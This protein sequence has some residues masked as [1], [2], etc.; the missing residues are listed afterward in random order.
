M[1]AANPR[2]S[3][4]LATSCVVCAAVGCTLFTDILNTG[5]ATEFGLDPATVFPSQGTVMVAFRNSTSFPAT[6]AAFKA[7]DAGDYSR[8]GRNFS[9]P[10]AAND[11]GN[12]V[13]ECPVEV[14]AP[15]ALGL[16]F[17]YDAS[18]A[19]T[20]ETDSGPQTIAYAGEPL[21]AGQTFTC[22]YVIE[23]RLSLST[24]Q[25]QTQ[26][27]TET[28][29]EQTTDPLAGGQTTQGDQ[30]AAQTTGQQQANTQYALSVRVIPGR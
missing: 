29:G 9:V 27:E 12:E 21:I 8:G 2:V 18:A 28:T 25:T 17:V 13:L 1:K 7:N 23:M 26:T 3:L 19:V 30:G 5:I 20:I 4:W 14:I 10:V 24:V 6:F 22:G 11:T 16:G 15:G